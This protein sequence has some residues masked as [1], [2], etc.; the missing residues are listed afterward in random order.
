MQTI[1]DFFVRDADGKIA[2]VSH[3]NNNEHI[4]AGASDILISSGIPYATSISEEDSKKSTGDIITIMDYY[5]K[6]L[7]TRMILAKSVRLWDM[8][9]PIGSRLVKQKT[10]K[11]WDHYLGLYLKPKL[12]K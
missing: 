1:T 6:P 11:E 3:R 10:S 12:T 4:V 7:F 8:S 5:G 9:K 2:I